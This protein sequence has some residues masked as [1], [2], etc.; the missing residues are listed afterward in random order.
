MS[1]KWLN[2][3]RVQLI[4]AFRNIVYL[5]IETVL[6]NPEKSLQPAEDFIAI[7]TECLADR[8]FV[9]D[10]QRE[11]PIE[12]D[13]DILKQACKDL[14][15]FKTDFVTKGYKDESDAEVLGTI[16]SIASLQL[17][18]PQI[19]P[20]TSKSRI[21][22]RP[23]PEGA[24]APQIDYDSDKPST[25]KA[26]N[27]QTNSAN[28]KNNK[29]PK[30]RD[31][32]LEVTNVLDVL[33]HLGDGFVRRVLSRYDNSE[34]AIA[35]ILEQNLPPDLI[36]ADKSEVYIPPDP[37]DAFYQQTGIKRFNVFDGDKYD[38]MTNDNPECIIKID[39]GF[40]SDPRNLSEMLDDKKDLNAVRHRYQEYTLVEGNEYDDEYDD[41]YDA[42]LESESRVIS[43]QMK[44]TIAEIED[45][46]EEEEEDE[47]ADE[48][49]EEKERHQ[50]QSNNRSTNNYEKPMNFCENPEDIRARYEARRAA[51]YGQ[52]ITKA[53]PPQRDVVGGP[54]GKGQTKEVT[55][56]RHKKDVNKS[57]RAN[58]N[59]KAGAAF[60]RS[61]GM[62][63]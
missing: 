51:K 44:S 24:A 54:K 46:S 12:L 28:S 7:M 42:L 18:P 19:A 9:I 36:H 35:A 15:D 14:D 2:E 41:S 27:S 22:K 62:M 61:K 38:I 17:E 50:K 23:Q 56:N 49:E 60:K 26:F 39:K 40:P 8:G 3:T 20:S 48:S 52:N 57:S 25:S 45:K 43:K 58:H 33:P 47:E 30:S 11:Y 4:K 63:G 37:Q 59:R 29:Q 55:T 34:D 5:H 32:D 10:Y 6:E 53:P 31:I 1:L 13:V 21:S 16:G